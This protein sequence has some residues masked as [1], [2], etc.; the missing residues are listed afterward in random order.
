[1]FDAVSRGTRYSEREDRRRRRNKFQE[2]LPRGK[3]F[4]AENDDNLVS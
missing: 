3:A 4:A 2:P 1:L